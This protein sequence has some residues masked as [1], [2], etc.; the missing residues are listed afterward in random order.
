MDSPNVGVL[1]CGVI[2]DR[3]FEA[4][5]VFEAFEVVS[6]A[7]IDQAR[8]EQKAEEFDITAASSTDAMFEDDDVDIIVNLT[9]P[10]VHA[11][12][13]IAAIE[14]GNHVYT[15]KPLAA[16]TQEAAELLDVAEEHGV[17]VGSAPD[18]M[19]G[20]GLQT[21]RHALDDGII[22]D[23]ISATAFFTSPGHEAWH[24]HASIFY[25]HGGGPL[26][27]MGPYYLTALTSVLGPAER[28]AGSTGK[29]YERR[30][31]GD[32]E[33]VDVEVPTHESGVVDFECGATATLLFTFDVGASSI[34]PQNG[35]EIHGTDGTLLA[36]DPNFFD[37]PVR[38]KTDDE[39]EWSEIQL[40]EG[41][42]GQQRGLGVAD[43]AKAVTSD[44]DHRTS[45]T[46]AYHV[47]EILEG[48]RTSSEDSTFVDPS[49]D[50]PRP[51]LLPESITST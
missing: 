28:V 3:Y 7:D 12:T 24:P 19:L 25:R 2:S 20:R 31:L 22:G 17:R 27:D 36:P 39:E 45:G 6:C 11:E 1:G 35:F 41:P 5:D 34:A 49:T 47:L 13:S 50:P 43:L 10:A 51:P 16:S 23:P 30:S 48:I 21:V 4:G 42:A 18:T 8:A 9:P 26:F 44:W 40:L 38:V 29:A 32:G 15:E 46:R 14:A 33:T 37:G